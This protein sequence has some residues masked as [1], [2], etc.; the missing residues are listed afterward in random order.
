MAF[1]FVDFLYRICIQYFL[2]VIR[3]YKLSGGVKLSGSGNLH[4]KTFKEI[5]YYIVFLELLVTY[6]VL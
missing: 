5:R 3:K 1:F 4:I 2:Y 6:V